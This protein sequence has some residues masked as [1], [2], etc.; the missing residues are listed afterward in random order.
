MSI[1]DHKEVLYLKLDALLLKKRIDVSTKSRISKRTPCSR[2]GAAEPLGRS[3]F[4]GS[5][6]GFPCRWVAGRGFRFQT[7]SL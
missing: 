4:G 3:D 1:S 2:P 6:P 5:S 7:C